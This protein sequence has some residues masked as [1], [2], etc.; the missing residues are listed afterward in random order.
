MDAPKARKTMV[1]VD[2]PPTRSVG[3]FSACHYFGRLLPRQQRS[4][5][6]KQMQLTFFM[7]ACSQA[8]IDLPEL[9]MDNLN[10]AVLFPT[11]VAHHPAG[12]QRQDAL[13]D[14]LFLMPSIPDTAENLS[15]SLR[16]PE[17]NAGRLPEANAIV[18]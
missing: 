2:L 12:P 10:G 5:F 4:R 17:E 14:D 3:F 15:R 6:H 7:F 8:N 9:D 13:A 11:F 18:L 1:N 16:T